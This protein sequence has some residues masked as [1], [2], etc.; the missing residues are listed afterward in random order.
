MLGIQIYTV[1]DL[2]TDEASAIQTIKELQNIGYEAIQLAG[3]I[4]T[5]IL[6]ANAAKKCG[7]K[8]IGIL[9]SLETCKE[10]GQ[11]L[12]E[13]ARELGA[14]DIGI[15]GAA[16]TAEEARAL[17]SDANEFAACVKKA[18]LSFSYHNH[19][20]EF[21]RVEQ[22]KTVMDILLEEFDKNNVDLMPDTYWLQH[23]GAD[24]RDFVDRY[25]DRITILH[26]K[27]MK[28][29]ADGV[30]FAEVG[31]GNLTMRG[32]TAEARNKGIGIYIVEQDRCD[33]DPL[34]SAKVS[35]DNLAKILEINNSNF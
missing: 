2:I 16:K 30:T 31:E 9:T 23:G 5:V 10:Y 19:S 18:G 32:I 22:D 20:H 3:G 24:V 26:V 6:H 21:I 25:A 8:V 15:S 7:M 35:Y 34:Y 11:K 4:D 13:I 14:K 1:R 27:D 12:I 29:I 17:A 28:R 33:G